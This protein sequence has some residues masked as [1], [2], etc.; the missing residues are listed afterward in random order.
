MLE[1]FFNGVLHRMTGK[2]AR[3]LNG[4]KAKRDMFLLDRYYQIPL[5]Q[6][7]EFKLKSYNDAINRYENA[8]RRKGVK[9]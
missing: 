5:K 2:Q 7:R 4:L 1:K 6:E 8:L 3:H 9:F